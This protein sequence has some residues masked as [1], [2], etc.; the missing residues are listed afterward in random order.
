MSKF[1]DR[2]DQLMMNIDSVQEY[3]LAVMDMRYY[4]QLPMRDVELAYELLKLHP[5]GINKHILAEYLGLNSNDYAG[6]DKILAELKLKYPKPKLF[7]YKHRGIT[8]VSMPDDKWRSYL[9]ENLAL[10][11]AK[12]RLKLR[13]P[14]TRQVGGKPKLT[15]A[16]VET[17]AQAKAERDTQVQRD[18]KLRRMK[19][20]NNLVEALPQDKSFTVQEIIENNYW[21]G[22]SNARTPQGVRKILNELIENGLIKF[23]YL[24]ST[25]GVSTR[26]R[27][28]S[29]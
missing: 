3:K 22:L 19:K 15:Q 10:R 18:K 5:L 23:S 14:L 11:Q 13:L 9:L 27:R 1:S 7:I 26:Y 17:R 16:E 25:R 24:Q 29:K 2:V 20:L 21:S 6:V 4:A 12:T 8:Y 28:W